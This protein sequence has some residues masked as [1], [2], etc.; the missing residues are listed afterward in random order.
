MRELKFRCW[1]E[2]HDG[3]EMEYFSIFDHAVFTDGEKG[4][5]P[6]MQYTGLKD[7]N[8]KEIYEG[9]IVL[10]A[11]MGE[12]NLYEVY[13][14]EEE[15]HYFA[16]PINNLDETES[17]LDSTHMQVIGNIYENPELI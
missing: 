13:Y 14:N 7:K 10:W 4:N 15:V 16:R 17:Y 9:D 11:H 12:T 3:H 5:I 1:S 2:Y 6:I 8:G